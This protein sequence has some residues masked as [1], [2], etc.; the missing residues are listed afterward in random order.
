VLLLRR[1]PAKVVNAFIKLEALHADLENT[2]DAASVLIRQALDLIIERSRPVITD[3][4]AQSTQALDDFLPELDKYCVIFNSISTNLTEITEYNGPR[5]DIAKGETTT[6][7]LT[8]FIETEGEYVAKLMLIS[9]V[10]GD[11][12]TKLMCMCDTR[13]TVHK[14]PNT[15][16]FCWL[17]LFVCSNITRTLPLKI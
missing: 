7:M 3:V 16:A 1:Q 17:L 2:E 8:N 12:Q 10:C 4:N 15:G 9:K 6:S 14:T 13:G 11:T 5:V